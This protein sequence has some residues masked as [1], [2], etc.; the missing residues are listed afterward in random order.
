MI[1]FVTTGH[2]RKGKSN[3]SKTRL[4]ILQPTIIASNQKLIL[5]INF[6]VLFQ[7]K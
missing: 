6:P 4:K 3:S 1:K 2:N 7:I 5:K